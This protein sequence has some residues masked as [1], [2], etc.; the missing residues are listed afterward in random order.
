MMIQEAMNKAV[1]GG[2]HIN[3]SDGIAT[4]YIGANDEYSAWTRTD[5]DSSFMVP[6]EETF[7][8][9][10]FW[11]AL[12]RTL[13]WSEGCD[14]VIICVHGAE[15]CQSCRGYYW[16]Y[17]WHCFIQALAHGNPPEAFFAR[18]ASSL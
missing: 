14:L 15:E 18:L 12:G 4:L 3:G 9:P 2:Y 8:D 7:L 16:M 1:A 17:Q 13:G 5:N 11:Q 6:V 10:R